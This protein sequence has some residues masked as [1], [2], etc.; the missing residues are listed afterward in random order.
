MLGGYYYRCYFIFIFFKPKRERHAH[1][2]LWDLFNMILANAF[3]LFFFLGKY[4]QVASLGATRGCARSGARWKLGTRGWGWGLRAGRHGRHRES[5]AVLGDRARAPGGGSG[6]ANSPGG[7]EGGSRAVAG[8]LRGGLRRRLP[9]FKPSPHALTRRRA[10]THAYL[11]AVITLISLKI[12][13]SICSNLGRKK[14]QLLAWKKGGRGKAV[15][16]LARQSPFSWLPSESLNF[17]RRSWFGRSRGALVVTS[18]LPIS[19]RKAP[20]FL[21]LGSTLQVSSYLMPPFPPILKPA[22]R[23]RAGMQRGVQGLQSNRPGA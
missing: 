7:S 11:Q 20:Y 10:R 4:L 17:C 18:H 22:G 5:T 12:T 23:Q 21:T 6:E 2:K 9:T 19:L 14:L 8:W 13:G 16:E 15:W 1:T 3:C